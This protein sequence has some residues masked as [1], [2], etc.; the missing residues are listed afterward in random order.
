VDVDTRP[1]REALCNYVLR[2]QGVQVPY[3][4][5]TCCASRACSCPIYPPSLPCIQG[6]E[7]PQCTAYRLY[8]CCTALPCVEDVP[9]HNPIKACTACRVSAMHLTQVGRG[10]RG[11]PA[12]Q[13]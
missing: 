10:A 2:I 13:V 5:Y 3:N 1:F 8:T 11:K 7:V 4:M 6:V 9:P 12:L